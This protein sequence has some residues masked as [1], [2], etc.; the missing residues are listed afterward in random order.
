MSEPHAALQLPI[1]A[2]LPCPL[3]ERYPSEPPELSE[4]RS[5]P[6]DEKQF[7][8]LRRQFREAKDW[9]A[10]AHVLLLHAAA[11]ETDASQRIKASDLSAQ[12]FELLFER[13]K[14]TQAAIHA[15]ARAVQL[16]PENDRIVDR[17]RKLYAAKGAQRELADLLR[18][19]LASQPDAR[20][21]AAQHVELG[22]LLRTEFLALS[23]AAHHYEQALER[24]PTH[25]EAAERLIEL[26]TRA[27]NWDLALRSLEKRLGQLD[28]EQ[29]RLRCAEIHRQ[30]AAIAAHRLHQVPSAARHLQAALKLV[31]DDVLALEAFGALYLASGKAQ[32]DGGAKSADI[33]FKAAELSRRK[34]N[35][36]QA[37]QLLRR[38]LGLRPEHSQGSALLERTLIEAQDWLALDE[39]YRAWL[40]HLRG[41]EAVP[42]LL[43]RAELLEE[44][45]HR[46]EEARQLYL[47]ASSFQA[48]HE[49]SWQRLLKL[50]TEGKDF[51]ALAELLDRLSEQRPDEIGTDTLLLAAKVYRDEL[52][53]E[54]R[55]A[56][57][58]YKVLER[59]P[60][61]AVAFEGYKEHWRRKH[62][63]VHLRDLILY[64]I[65]Q[66]SERPLGESPLGEAAFADEFV[67]LADICERR[68][69]DIDAAIDTWRRMA[70][71]YPTDPRPPKNI[72]RIEKRTRMWDNMVTV[73]EAELAQTT[74]PIKRL[75]ILKRLTQV[76]RDRQ[77]N[78]QRAIELHHE[79]LELSPD[80]I[81]A[82]RALTML[83][84]RAG[85]FEQVVSM[86]RDQY[87]RSRSKTE[88]TSLLRRMAEIWHHELDAPD[89][90]LW[91]CR[92]ILEAVPSDK[93]ALARTQQIL[94]EQE[95]WLE[96][97]T[98]LEGELAKTPSPSAKVRL[99]QRMARLAEVQMGDLPRAIA[100]MQ[101]LANQRSDLEVA[102]RL[103]ELLQRTERYEELAERLAKVADAATTPIVRRVDLRMRLGELAQTRL[104]DPERARACFEAVLEIR[105]DHRGAL[106]RLIELHRQAQDWVRLVDTMA[107]LEGLQSEADALRLG[108]ERADILA[109]RA[110]DPAAAAKVLEG[111]L[112]HPDGDVEPMNHSLL[113]NY[114]LARDYRSVVQQA[115]TM[116][117]AID[118]P[119]ERRRL[120]TLIKDTWADRLNNKEAALAAYARYIDEAPEDLEGLS[121]LAELHLQAGDP[122]AALTVL[123][124]RI[125]LARD[126]DLQIATYDRMAEI[127]ELHAQKPVAAMDYLRR[128]VVARPLDERRFELA[129]GLAYRTQQWEALLAIQDERCR[130]HAHTGDTPR[131]IELCREAAT[132]ALEQ[133]A[134]PV[135]AFGWMKRAYFAALR[136]ELDREALGKML[137]E[138]ASTHG[139][140]EELLSVLEEE[141]HHPPTPGRG[142]PVEL[143]LEA[144]EIAELQL[145]QPDRAVGFLQRA[146]AFQPED[147]ELAQRLEDT[148]ERYRLFGPV[149][150][151]Y[152]TRLE[153]ADA[154][155]YRLT[156]YLKVAEIC[157]RELEEPAE[158]MEW[159][160]RAYRSFDPGDLDESTQ[161]FAA[162]VALAE[163]HALW[164]RLADFH[165]ERANRAASRGD[166]ELRIEALQAAARLFAEPLDRPLAA[167]RVLRV[168]LL[169]DPSDERIMPDIERLAEV[170]DDELDDGVPPI[171]T[172]ALLHVLQQRSAQRDDAQRI[173]IAIRRARLREE[174]LRDPAGAIVEWLRVLRL[175][176]DHGE[177]LGELQ[178]LA[179]AH[180][181]WPTVVFWW[182]YVLHD[183]QAPELRR[184]AF[185]A[186]AE[187]Y[188]GPLERAEYALRARLCAWRMAGTLPTVGWDPEDPTH[189]REIEEPHTHLW[190]L[191]R[192]A[193]DYTTPPVPHD[194]WLDPDVEVPEQNDLKAWARTGIDPELLDRMPMADVTDVVLA[195]LR[196]LAPA[197]AEE[198]SLTDVAVQAN[199]EPTTVVE[200]G[201]SAL[202]ELERSTLANLAEALPGGAEAETS[203]DDVEEL[204]VSELEELDLVEPPKPPPPPRTVDRGLPAIPRP[205]GP[206]LPP[207]PRVAS[208]WEELGLAYAEYEAPTA[209]DKAEVA[210]VLAWMWEGG[211]QQPAR[212]FSALERAL[213][214]APE[215]PVALHALRRLA[216]LHG[217][218]DRLAGAYEL[219]LSEAIVPE[220]AVALGDRVAALYEE[221]GDLALAEERY[222]GVLQ[223]VGNHRDALRALCRIYQAQGRD[224]DYA[225]VF[226]ALLEAE[227]ADLEEDAVV[228]RT[229]A[230]SE[231]LGD[232]LGRPQEAIER[233]TLLAR[234]FPHRL[235]V[236]RELIDRLIAAEKWQPA[237][238]AM[239]VA[240]EAIHDEDFVVDNLERAAEIYEVQLGL[241]E[242][243]IAAWNEVVQ[244]RHA[245]RALEKLQ[246]LYTAMG[247]YDAVLPILGERLAAP[248]LDAEAR[249]TLLVAKARAL[250]ESVTDLDEL[251]DAL[252]ELRDEAPHNDELTAALARTHA[253]RGDRARSI[254]LLRAH[255]TATPVEPAD[256]YLRLTRE[257]V[258][259]LLR[260]DPPDHAGALEVVERALAYHSSRRE[261]LEQRVALCRAR[262]DTRRLAEGLIDLGEADGRL[263]AADLFRGPL[264]DPERARELYEAVLVEAKAT[265]GADAE[266]ARRATTALDGLLE[267]HLDRDDTDGALAFIE[268]ELAA[269]ES[270]TL[271]AQLLTARGRLTFHTTR[272]VEAADQHFTAALQA[273]P[274]YAR[275]KLGRAQVLLDAGRSPEAEQL[276]VDAVDALGLSPR[277]TAELVEALLLLGRVLEA[278]G[279][280]GEA[281]RRLTAAARHDPD[282]LEIRA[283]I[284]RNRYAAG[285]HRDVITA[286][287]QLEQQLS[288]GPRPLPHE[289][290]Q[291]SEI[292]VVAAQTELGLDKIGPALARLARAAELA[293]DNV[294]ALVPLVDLHRDRGEVREAARYAER[295][296]ASPETLPNVSRAERRLDAAL[297]L[298]EASRLGDDERSGDEDTAEQRR[299]R[300]LALL[301][302][303]LEPPAAPDEP[304]LPRASLE[305]AFRAV[306][307]LQPTLALTALDAV[308]APATADPHT[309]ELLLEG[310]QVALAADDHD[311]ALRYAEE[312]RRLA[313]DSGNVVL[314]FASVYEQSGRTDRVEALVESY[315]AQ[316]SA[317][318]GR[319]GLDSRLELLRRLAELHRDRP[320][321][322]LAAL[323]RIE[324]LDP[325]AMT[326]AEREWLSEL[327]ADENPHGEGALRNHRQLLELA[328]TQA[329]SLATVA[330]AWASAGNL[331]RAHA[332]YTVLLLLDP[333]HREALRF[334]E[335]NREVGESSGAID[336]EAFRPPAPPASGM[337]AV[338]HTLWESGHMV[339]VEQLPRFEIPADARIS[340]MGDSALSKVWGE[341]LKRFGQS[342]AA[343]VDGRALRLDPLAL[344]DG[345]P[346]AGF[347]SVHCQYPPVVIAHDRALDS[348]TD[349][350]RFALGRALTF[351]RGVS[352]FA[353]GLRRATLA[354]LLS[355]TLLAFHPRHARRKHHH[356]PDGAV[357]RLAQELAR[358][359][360]MRAARQIGQIFRD[361]DDEPFASHQWRAWV[362]QTG[363][364]FGLVW[365]GR[366][367]AALQVLA[368][369]FAP[370]PALAAHI[371]EEPDLRALVAFAFS[372]TYV[373]ARAQLG[374]SIAPAKRGA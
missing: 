203:G 160:R 189:T 206:A 104:G 268:Q 63:W 109:E 55:A 1:A 129:Q 192:A 229:M 371:E 130:A 353:T 194:P 133:L 320:R 150:E 285:R 92:E 181:R 321:K 327:Y 344:P 256:R 213:L 11:L 244:R 107:R 235:E 331:A 276:L 212:A 239:R 190:D 314:A 144:S 205:A 200:I 140:W 261:L 255:W 141:L 363:D 42:L 227:N 77:V 52:G 317:D 39:L 171:G 232:R 32:E 217:A 364:R 295:L 308:L 145:R 123:Q 29:D 172:L 59:E 329:R 185:E 348:D 113:E 282:N 30:I 155:A 193:G 270:P 99:M 60:F 237:I 100:V 352:L 18:W 174:R 343:L 230:L 83:Y 231:L 142:D 154:P 134:A 225:E 280:A 89:E 265:E 170:I 73:Q 258:E 94:E 209:A 110:N 215:H 296:A 326:V 216:E 313:P 292:L 328:P 91:A 298:L 149:I 85:D 302:E 177:A 138:L 28:P 262:G 257:L 47:E 324:A 165:L 287:D 201:D 87:E 71:Q 182:A 358:K 19:R 10:L 80:D 214:L 369:G 137:R 186:L 360:P 49:T 78:P 288:T 307:R 204:E 275:A 128:A 146:H 62:N 8:K 95:R 82:T 373:D 66:A 281:Y 127:A 75:D 370:G 355:A 179:R 15:L 84:D 318:A 273:D 195:D 139:L 111:L 4:Y 35:S 164:T 291:I 241:P 6:A 26:Y 233:L 14:D 36:A 310:V 246:Q 366:I 304:P 334:V 361:H 339:L 2:V 121:T 124:R 67:E 101:D 309:V 199:D 372:E 278:S 151:L 132:I 126:V 184:A 271:R 156:C 305:A 260:S 284:V 163:R 167:L 220:H 196:A 254:A 279:R 48:P 112:A 7:M 53:L 72:E 242:R 38:C 90:A 259:M 197:A 250:Q 299:T 198:L 222:R 23:D 336:L 208:A 248:G 68:L 300:G 238:E 303:S 17:L 187:L 61:N 96:L 267:L 162:I 277:H 12:A 76:Y 147:E 21:A 168:A 221:R 176:P 108:L 191:A 135:V 359:L 312:A 340:P 25:A 368:P 122:D 143:L 20:N 236:H 316:A 342:K 169:E 210:L 105:P 234:R 56:V 152:Q 346:N 93:E 362:R 9:R 207:R 54:D 3:P 224:S 345:N 245:P 178:R 243:A 70:A 228:E 338:L 31:P 153:R 102:D 253:R 58:Y 249:E 157:E 69:G 202:T 306:S 367:D 347:F 27:G 119:A 297:L 159:L 161:A 218:W 22:D 252:A 251:A 294:R 289:A 34:G 272:D 86:L 283:A 188:E 332:A 323:E 357:V 264:E 341:A 44:H 79:I 116:L 219:L 43:R 97:Y 16:R 148:A 351:T 183:A 173:E 37:L 269:T 118:A 349:E 290:R 131:E 322:A 33:F 114:E 315:L 175:A 98:L 247:S 51:Y 330:A 158:A 24:D 65:E 301:A 125:D 211:A 57:Y 337:A 365:S 64:Q 335:A 311:A 46:R 41:R 81:Q 50:Y 263:E 240:A 354:Q 106:E 319:G 117:L 286:A 333:D 223:I 274:G 5:H 356:K 13:V 180:D 115:E 266:A 226:A 74:D 166:T 325:T 374:V 103:F 293:P 350:L 88:R 120:F 40:T 45:L 136:V